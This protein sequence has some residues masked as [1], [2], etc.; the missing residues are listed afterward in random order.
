MNVLQYS[1][2]FVVASHTVMQLF[3]HYTVRYLDIYRARLTMR[4]CIVL[5]A[6]CDD[7]L[8]FGSGNRAALAV[9]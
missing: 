5:N 4:V 1:V 8:K 2:V 6:T 3:L 9:L 7:T